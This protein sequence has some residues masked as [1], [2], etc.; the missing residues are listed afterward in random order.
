MT[1]KA[2]NKR[3]A[4]TQR[5]QANAALAAGGRG[6]DGRKIRHIPQ[7]TL[8][9]L[10]PF[11]DK[12]LGCKVPDQSTMP[13]SVAVSVDRTTMSSDATY[14]GSVRAFR[15]HP[16]SVSVGAGAMASTTTWTWLA[17]FGG[18]T[19]T[20]NI[21]SLASSFGALRCVAWGLKLRCRLSDTNAQGALHICYVPENLNAGVTTWQFPTSVS[22]M[23]GL[24]GYKCIP[25]AD[26]RTGEHTAPGLFTDE[27]AFR[28]LDPATAD[29]GTGTTIFP[30]TGWSTILI[31]VEGLATGSAQ[32]AIDVDIIHH[33]E[34]L[35]G[36]LA[37]ITPL[38]PAA[39][40]SPAII[41]GTKYAAQNE[42]SKEGIRDTGEP[43]FFADVVS[44]F[45]TGIAIANGA[46]QMWQM[47]SPVFL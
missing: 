4:A 11:S 44:A 12:V 18:A 5:Q 26:L 13:S 23:S 29:Q 3:R 15:Y 31:A 22:A 14:G 41:A 17:S 7:F 47:L 35:P 30:L 10:N 34:C 43:S 20:N 42:L 33:W 19:T 39:P 36:T 21:G 40:N 6:M 2:N 32:A 25:L 46:E 24:A 37:A 1:K 8:A 28:Y 45:Q 9:N 27:T 16:R 38:S